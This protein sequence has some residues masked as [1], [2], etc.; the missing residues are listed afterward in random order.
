[1]ARVSIPTIRI[2]AQA[3][4]GPPPPLAVA[5]ERVAAFLA[6]GNAAV[7]TGAG[8]STDSGIRAYRGEE[9]RYLNPNF[10]PIFYNDLVEDS[11]RGHSFRQRYW[12]RSFL[13]YP[14]IL[15]TRPNPTHAALAA[16]VHTSHVRHL[17]TQN[18][19]GLHLDALRAPQL[20]SRVLE[21]HGTLHRVHCRQ[22]HLIQRDEYQ[23]QLGLL[24]PE[25]ADLE[26]SFRRSGNKPR[27]NPDGDVEL[28]G[29]SFDNF[30]IPVCAACQRAGKVETIIKPNVVFFGETISQAVKDLSYQIIEET[31]R[32][33]V[34]GTTLA[35][36]SAYRLVKHALELSKPIV[37]LNLGPTRAEGLPQIDKIEAASG[38]VLLEVA[39]QLAA[40]RLAL[41]PE[42]RDVLEAGV[43]TSV[44]DI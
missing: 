5:I 8:V 9:G 44:E 13:G 25:W 34:V 38:P 28:D 3:V 11:P 32:L 29:V 22:D 37:V 24:N 19:D 42:F 7:L 35:T 2:A 15:A 27:T 30:S 41:E 10:K 26:E 4:A 1:M 12:A 14:R 33:L 17:I 21:L 16:L 18:V 20:H 23:I 43:I 31:D 36:Y 40:G 39:R 6:R